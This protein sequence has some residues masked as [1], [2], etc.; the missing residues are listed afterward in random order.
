M[1]RR[2]PSPTK[3]IVLSA[4]PDRAFGT[5]DDIKSNVLR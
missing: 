1:I 2:P 5:Y 3:P 4:G